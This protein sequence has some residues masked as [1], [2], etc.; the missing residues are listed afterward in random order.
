M[1]NDDNEEYLVQTQKRVV[2]TPSGPHTL[3]LIKV[4]ERTQGRLK[5][6]A[7]VRQIEFLCFSTSHHS[8]NLL[9]DLDQLELSHAVRYYKRAGDHECTRT[10][11]QDMLRIF[12]KARREIDPLCG[13]AKHFSCIPA[14][15]AATLA[16]NRGNRPLLEVLGGQVPESWIR[17]DRIAQNDANGEVDGRD[18]LLEEEETLDKELG[19]DELL[20]NVIAAELA[21]EWGLD[22]DATASM[23]EEEEEGL[24]RNYALSELSAALKTQLKDMERWRTS[25]LQ[26]NRSNARVQQVTFASD[27]A[28]FLRFLGWVDAR[29]GA[30]ESGLDFTIFGHEHIVSFVEEFASWCVQERGIS[31]ASLASYLNSLLTCA[32]YAAVTGVAPVKDDIIHGL[33]NLRAQSSKQA[34]EDRMYRP[35]HKEWISWSEAQETRFNAIQLMAESPPENRWGAI[36][37]QEMVCI[38]CLY[39]TAPPDRVG[40]IRTLS[41]HR[42]LKRGGETGWYIDLTAPRLH[43][44]SKFYGPCQ[45][46]VSRLS[47][48]AIDKLLQLRKGDGFDY[49]EYDAGAGRGEGAPE[50]L[51]YGS[52]PTRC[53]DS[54]AWTRR[55]KQCFERFSPRKCSTCPRLLRSAFITE[56]RS[57]ATCPQD[58]KEAAVAMKHAIDTQSSDVYD[59]ETHSRLTASAFKWCTQHAERWE[60]AK[61]A[62][63]PEQEQ[64]SEPNSLATTQEA[65]YDDDGDAFEPPSSPMAAPTQ[66]ATNAS[67]A[68]NVAVSARESPT[69]T[70]KTTRP[71][72]N[73]A[74]DAPAA[75]E[76][77]LVQPTATR[78]VSVHGDPPM[79]PCSPAANVAVTARESPVRTPN[80]VRSIL[81]S[82]NSVSTTSEAP[83]VQPAAAQA[84]SVPLQAPVAASPTPM[85]RLPSARVAKQVA[86]KRVEEARTDPSLTRSA[87]PSPEESFELELITGGSSFDGLTYRVLWTGYP[88]LLDWWERLDHTGAFDDPSY[89]QRL[90]EVMPQGDAPEVSA[91]RRSKKAD[92]MVLVLGKPLDGGGKR[93]AFEPNGSR[94][95]MDLAACVLDDAPPGDWL[96]KMDDERLYLTDAIL[97]TWSTDPALIKA[98][99]EWR[100]G[101]E[102]PAL[103]DAMAVLRIAAS[104]I[105]A[106]GGGAQSAMMELLLFLTTPTMEALERAKEHALT[107]RAGFVYGGVIHDALSVINAVRE[108]RLGEMC[109]FARRYR[110][111]NP[112]EAAWHAALGNGTI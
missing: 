9:W 76:V 32:Q 26:L 98:R 35:R 94:H 109:F 83:P 63:P 7:F 36:A 33:I 100:D 93:E 1:N 88:H 44:T 66:V 41:F 80:T 55:V 53:L 34:K 42:T 23:I 82:I 70:P 22:A 6:W 4:P 50:Y 37:L 49:N 54:S 95:V 2:E 81:E 60:A 30:I 28:S 45:S 89:E 69:R 90:I 11:F 77:P 5:W 85:A 48:Q 110:A 79:T 17:A 56:L 102:Y 71:I 111:S 31:Y 64:A 108:E 104:A 86:K 59:L 57:D 18:L 15:V 58:V 24:G 52:H 112:A 10:Q 27:K 46:P 78:A 51:F 68:A 107:V 43:K 21:N 101:S 92:Y 25:V 87:S 12:N 13:V 106:R 29:P 14:K 72:A 65:N 99:E 40:V 20:A 47:A 84:V 62:P 39:T 74:I 8:S 16:L 67:P 97:D 3:Y 73:D 19:E 103:E 61:R 91:G 105:Q 96:L 75:S 38:L